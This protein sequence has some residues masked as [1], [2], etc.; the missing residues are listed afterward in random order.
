MKT[1]K[2]SKIIPILFIL[3]SGF[4]AEAKINLKSGKLRL[5][6]AADINDQLIG[7]EPKVDTSFDYVHQ[8]DMEMSILGIQSA[9]GN[10]KV[11]RVK[12]KFSTHLFN[13]PS[14][15]LI[16]RFVF[17]LQHKT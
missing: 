10:K 5:L 12:S 14:G 11:M 16:E 9:H 7:F 1:K 3:L 8:N 17:F 13:V 15:K 6:V 4:S 2:L